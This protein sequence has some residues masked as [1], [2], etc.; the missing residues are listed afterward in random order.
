MSARFVS[1]GPGLCVRSGRRG[2][3]QAVLPFPRLAANEMTGAE[4]GRE[5]GAEVRLRGAEQ[6]E[7]IFLRAAERALV[8]ED[9][10]RREGHELDERE[11]AASSERLRA[12]PFAGGHERLVITVER[13]NVVAH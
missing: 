11:E 5:A 7:A 1:I 8:R 2:P 10:A 6:L 13:G 12:G 9:D 3:Q 4:L